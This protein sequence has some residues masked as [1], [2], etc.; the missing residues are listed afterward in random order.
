MNLQR[1]EKHYKAFMQSCGMNMHS[2]HAKETPRRIAHFFNE[3][4]RGLRPADFSFTS[5]PK[6]PRHKYDQLVIVGDIPFAS[7]CQHHHV[8]FTGLC[9]VG[10]LPD[11]SI[12]GLSKIVRIV[13]WIA[14]KPSI[15]E[16]LTEEIADLLLKHLKPKAVCVL[17]S[18]VTHYCIDMRGIQKHGVKTTT[19]AI[20][21]KLGLDMKGE[22]L[23]LVS[24]K[25]CS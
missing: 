6:N 11:I 14:H 24:R 13:D 18:D 19:H 12:I 4:T 17:L 10:Y 15:Q 20:R 3:Y 5:F 2:P 9:H 7:I 1:A 22:F 23:S 21:G 8:P 16:D 25:N